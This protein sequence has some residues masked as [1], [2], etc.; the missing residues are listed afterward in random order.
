MNGSVGQGGVYCRS[1]A[2]PRNPATSRSSDPCCG[3]YGRS[4]LAPGD[5]APAPLRRSARVIQDTPREPGILRLRGAASGAGR[6]RRLIEQRCGSSPAAFGW[7][8][9]G[10]ELD[11]IG[12]ANHLRPAC[13]SRGPAISSRISYGDEL[14]KKRCTNSGL[15]GEALAQL[16][17]LRGDADRAGVEMA[18]GDIITQPITTR[19]GCSGEAVLLSAKQRRDDTRRAP[20]SAARPPGRRCDRAGG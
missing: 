3:P 4:S 7:I 14:E 6:H 20:S 12:A 13:G 5:R 15:P 18:D 2:S 16:G 10:C 11:A 9:G 1:A 19:A 17:I 8:D